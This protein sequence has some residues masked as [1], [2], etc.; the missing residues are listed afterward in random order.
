[1]AVGG[2]LSFDCGVLSFALGTTAMAVVVCQMVSYGSNLI[3][4]LDRG[5]LAVNCEWVRG[6]R[7]PA[8]L[9]STRRFVVV[10]PI[11]AFASRCRKGSACVDADG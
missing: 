9:S 4:V 8:V 6:M 2:L 5:I 11:R 1:M 10:K 7:G 3:C